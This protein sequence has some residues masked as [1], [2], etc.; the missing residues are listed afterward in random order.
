MKR[1]EMHD[2]IYEELKG[3]I[4]FHFKKIETEMDRSLVLSIAADILDLIE[5]AG[6]EP[7]AKGTGR[8][9]QTHTRTEYYPGGSQNIYDY[10][11]IKENKWENE[12]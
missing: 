4:N 2:K 5:D 6:M 10:S 12:D 3:S 7:P 9:N 8:Y 11:E 1:S